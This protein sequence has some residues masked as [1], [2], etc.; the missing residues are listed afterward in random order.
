MLHKIPPVLWGISIGVLLSVAFGLI[1]L[2]VL[3][4]PDSA[5]YLFAGL[6][7]LGGPLIGGLVAAAKTPGP[8]RIRAFFFPGFVTFAIVSVLFIFIYLVQPIFA[9]TSVQLP[10]ACNRDPGNFAPPPDLAY[11]LPNGDTG[12][13]LASSPQFILV[14]MI[15]YQQPP[16]PSTLFLVD[17]SS[18]N[19]INRMDFSD[20]IISASF[21]ESTLY[22]FNDKIGYF[23]DARSGEPEKSFMTMDNYGGL[24]ESDRP[25]LMAASSTGEWH[26][27]T[28]AI[29]TSWNVD[30]SVNSRRHLTFD[31][32]AL[33]CFVEGGT[34]NV[35]VLK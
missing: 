4:E 18:N 15:D 34:H 7:F 31:G 19:I 30:G 2:L 29:I 26:L 22:L 27:E 6:V 14:S 10:E 32:T 24:S 23:L 17:K 1:Y 33:G 12:I 3:R 16:F 20:D 21:D 8:R 25:I 5:F 28:S 13:L 11:T 35:S 9:R